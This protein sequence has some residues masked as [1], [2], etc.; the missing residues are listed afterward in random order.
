MIFNGIQYI[1]QQQIQVDIKNRE[2]ANE[3]HMIVGKVVM[4]MSSVVFFG[5]ETVQKSFILNQFFERSQDRDMSRNVF[6]VC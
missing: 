4:G 2:K 1:H 3:T 6:L 5:N